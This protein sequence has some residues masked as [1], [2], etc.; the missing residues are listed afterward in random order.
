MVIK[1]VFVFPSPLL[2][3]RCCCAGVVRW[4]P[5]VGGG[6]PRRAVPFSQKTVD[7]PRSTNTAVP[8][9]EGAQENDLGEL[10]NG[11]PTGTKKYPP[12]NRGK[13]IYSIF[14][15]QEKQVVD[16][17]NRFKIDQNK[18]ER[19]TDACKFAPNKSKQVKAVVGHN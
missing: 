7:P 14:N 2:L 17:F 4:S 6:A 11:T 16:I 8:T 18:S 5:V 1:S 10:S 13:H 15:K 3:L 9:T 12:K 19:T